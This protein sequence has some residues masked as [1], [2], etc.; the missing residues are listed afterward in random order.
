MIRAPVLSNEAR[1]V[2]S[3]IW[4]TLAALMIVLVMPMRNGMFG[5]PGSDVWS[6]VPMRPWLAC[7]GPSVAGRVGVTIP[8]NGLSDLQGTN[9]SKK[10]TRGPGMGISSRGEWRVNFWRKLLLLG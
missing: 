8:Y 4:F 7:A 9:A 5:R 2:L 10:W 1:R 3:G 6:A